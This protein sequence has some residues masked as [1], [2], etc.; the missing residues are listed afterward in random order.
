MQR[1]FCKLLIIGNLQSTI[2]VIQIRGDGGMGEWGGRF[3]GSWIF[4]KAVVQRSFGF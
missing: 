4:I 3:I 1:K 2:L